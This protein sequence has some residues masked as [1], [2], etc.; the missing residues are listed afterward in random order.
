MLTMTIM[1]SLLSIRV[2]FALL[3]FVLITS[4]ALAK[5]CGWKKVTIGAATYHSEY[6]T[7]AN[8]KSSLTV[9]CG[10]DWPLKEGDKRVTAY[11]DYQG[12][13]VCGNC[14]KVKGPE[15]SV[16]VRIIDRCEGCDRNDGNGQGLDL[17]RWAFG[18]IA[19]VS[20]G[21]IN[22][23]NWKFIP[24][25]PGMLGYNGNIQY[26]WKDGSSQWWI[27]LQLQNS[28]QPIG[29]VQ[30]KGANMNSWAKTDLQAHNYYQFQDIPSGGVST[31]ITIRLKAKYTLEKVT[32]KVNSIGD[33]EAQVFATKKQFHNGCDKCVKQKKKA[34]CKKKKGC[35]WKSK[36]CRYK[37]V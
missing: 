18:K 16:V 10:L 31:P 32:F 27:Q 25:P 22:K 34:A 12:G 2:P 24:C 1:K 8:Q 7:A 19:D 6:D 33:S 4:T 13:A 15:G 28:V 3:C 9:N 17:S 29:S 35:A 20:D 21:I 11:V 14:L 30:Y 26:R 36:K 5:Q 23:M 37:N